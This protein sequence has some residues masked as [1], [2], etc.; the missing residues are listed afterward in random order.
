MGRCR[1]PCTWGVTFL[2]TSSE[3]GNYPCLILDR[4]DLE[5][6]FFFDMDQLALLHY[7]AK[8]QGAGA[9]LS[10]KLLPAIFPRVS[11]YAKKHSSTLP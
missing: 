6:A 3:Q 10:R 5:L 11:H 8:P 1:T 9:T 7:M 2:Q 4:A